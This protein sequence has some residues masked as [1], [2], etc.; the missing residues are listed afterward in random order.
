MPGLNRSAQRAV[1]NWFEIC[2]FAMASTAAWIWPVGMLGSKIITFGP[3]SDWMDKAEEGAC[4]LAST[5]DQR[6]HLRKIPDVVIVIEFF[7][8]GTVLIAGA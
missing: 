2:W 7:Q 5:S 8:S 6:V 3:M 1:P 4:A